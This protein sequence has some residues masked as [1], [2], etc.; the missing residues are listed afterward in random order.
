MQAVIVN[1]FQFVLGLNPSCFLMSV[2]LLLSFFNY[3]KLCL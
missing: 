3:Q 2:K 1:N